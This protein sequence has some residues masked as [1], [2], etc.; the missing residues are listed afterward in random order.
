MKFHATS[1]NYLRDILH[2]YAVEAGWWNDLKTGEPLDRNDAELIC[3]MHSELSEALEGV[4][5]GGKD[6]HLPH[7]DV[8]EV[9]LADCI[10]RI[11]DYCGAR[12]MDIGGAVIEKLAYNM[13][14]E[15]HKIENRK[16][17]GGKKI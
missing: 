13:T 12:K 11:L 8:V 16:K 3:L 7:R 2:K 9:E 14:R 15:D 4:R 1:L 5:K 10:I 6:K 17:E